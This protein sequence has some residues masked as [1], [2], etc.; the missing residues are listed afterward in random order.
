MTRTIPALI[1][2]LIF[3]SFSFTKQVVT[4]PKR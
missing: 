3:P 1:L 4:F 2:L